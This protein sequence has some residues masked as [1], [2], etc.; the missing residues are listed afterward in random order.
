M[1]WSGKK[2]ASKCHGFFD[3]SGKLEKSDNEFRVTVGL[4]QCLETL[5]HCILAMS[6]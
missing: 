6:S 1:P 4:V 2:T 5:I 3:G